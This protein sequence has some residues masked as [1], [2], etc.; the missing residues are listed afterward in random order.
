MHSC[1][2][3][4]QTSI[5][6]SITLVENSRQRKEIIQQPKGKPTKPIIA[7]WLS[8]LFPIQQEQRP[9]RPQ[10]SRPRRQVQREEWQEEESTHV[11]TTQTKSQQQAVY[12][13]Q[14][15]L[16]STQNQESTTQTELEQQPARRQ[17]QP[18]QQPTTP[19]SQPEP[20]QPTTQQENEQQP[21][22]RNTTPP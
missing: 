15:E 2:Y 3:P 20:E 1:S 17:P 22:H 7:R 21:D 19:Q 16:D 5:E 6:Q 12:E 14:P 18:E 11:D 9:P 10:A 13:Q 4:N 8:V